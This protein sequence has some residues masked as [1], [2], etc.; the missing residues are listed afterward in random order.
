M[1]GDFGARDP[2]P[3]E[4]ASNFAENVLGNVNTEHK[5][6]I[7][8]AKALSLSKQNLVPVSE[9]MPED[10]ANKLMLKVIS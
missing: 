10:E 4:I 8:I 2:Y 1:I 7:P 6:L 3:A 9:A 5:I